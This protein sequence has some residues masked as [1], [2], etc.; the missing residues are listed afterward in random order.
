MLTRPSS[1]RRFASKA[2]IALTFA[3][4]LPLTASRAAQS[5]DVP[6]TGPK[7]VST[8]AAPR[9][10]AAAGA[11]AAFAQRTVSANQLP[12]PN[13][14][15]V[16][17]GRNDVAFMADDTILMDGKRMTIEQLDASERAR[18]RAAILRSRQDLVRDR[19]RLPAE[20]AEARR[21]ADRARTGELR[22]EHLREIA[23]LRHELAELDSRAAE[24]RSEGE[25]PAKR[26]AEILR[27]LREEQAIDIAAEERD[28]IDEADTGKRIAALRSDE[29]QLERLLAKLNQ[30]ERR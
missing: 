2:L 4:V 5:V 1:T 6:A 18:L 22:R 24:L 25:D 26:R 10:N 19:E 16:R 13:L 30:I 14:G 20:L 12:Y 29:R 27:D 11:S 15:G 17:M 7:T 3:A 21:E 8:A 28:A 9:Q 23:D